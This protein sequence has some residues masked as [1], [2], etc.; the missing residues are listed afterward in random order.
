[1]NLISFRTQVRK[2][3]FQAEETENANILKK[4][5]RVFYIQKGSHNPRTETKSI[6]N[7]FRDSAKSFRVRS[8]SK[9]ESLGH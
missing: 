8:N 3:A 6:T 4:E 7:N 5:F 1:M 9:M 2:K